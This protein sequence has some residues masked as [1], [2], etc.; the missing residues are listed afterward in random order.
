MATICH[1]HCVDVLR[2][3]SRH[4]AVPTD[5]ERMAHLPAPSDPEP[6]GGLPEVLLS[7]P[8]RDREI[9]VLRIVDG[10]SPG[11]IAEIVGLAPGTVSNIVSRCLSE[12]RE[13]VPASMTA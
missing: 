8:A 2:A 11:E 4:L 7:L 10:L 5:P 6:A 13:R 1:H 9:L 12:L 3:R